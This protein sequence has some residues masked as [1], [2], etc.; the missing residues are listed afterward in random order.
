MFCAISGEVPE[1]PVVSRKSGLVFEKRL[2]EKALTATGGKCPETG[3]DLTSEDLI[4][5]KTSG[6]H[7]RPIAASATSF[8]GLMQHLQSEWDALM[9]ESHNL[10]KSLS[11]TRQELAH[12][13]Y[14]CDAATR[15]ISRLMAEKEELKKALANPVDVEWSLIQ[16]HRR[17]ESLASLTRPMEMGMVLLALRTEAKT[18]CWTRTRQTPMLKKSL[19]RA[20]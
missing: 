3:E 9:L 16:G 7:A 19:S 10:K 17:S 4:S 8:P 11:K 20:R 1:E 2:I 5:V 18:S 14:Q 6:K 12:A 13:L 15:V